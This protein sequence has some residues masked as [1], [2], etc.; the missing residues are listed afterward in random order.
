MQKISLL[1]KKGWILSFLFI[2]LGTTAEPDSFSDSTLDFS[3]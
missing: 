3:I 1:V 2:I